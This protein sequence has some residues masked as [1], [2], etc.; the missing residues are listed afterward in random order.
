MS[1]AA[2]AAGLDLLTKEIAT[3]SLTDG[4][5]VDLTNRLSLMLVYNTGT[6][7]GFNIGPFTFA[8]NVLVTIGAIAMILRIVRPLA[9][10]DPRAAMSLGLLTGGAIG[11]LSSMLVGPAGVA[12]FLAL[13]LGNSATVVMNVA[14]LM[15]WGGA[16]MLVPVVARLISLVRLE[17]AA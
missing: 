16:L 6:A 5:M 4:R 8:L 11:N 14:D 17:R 1:A 10:V 9:A 2:I 15:L 13:E 7:G 12:D 3:R